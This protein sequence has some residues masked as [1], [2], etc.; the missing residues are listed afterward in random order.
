MGKF[1]SAVAAS[2]IAGVVGLGLGLSVVGCSNSTPSAGKDKMS[3]DKMKDDKMSGDK[4]KDDK[5]KSDK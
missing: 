2:L 1:K 5:M 4:M 3:G